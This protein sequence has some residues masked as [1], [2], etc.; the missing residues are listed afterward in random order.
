MLYKTPLLQLTSNNVYLK[1]KILVYSFLDILTISVGCLC[2]LKSFIMLF[3]QS[4][5]LHDL[6]K[7]NVPG[8]LAWEPTDIIYS[9]SVL[10]NCLALQNTVAACR[11]PI[12]TGAVQLQICTQQLFGVV[13]VDLDQICARD[14][15][16]SL[17]VWVTRIQYPGML[18]GSLIYKDGCIHFN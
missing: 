15:S 2:I 8:I 14:H 4:L 17:S 18:V 6:S 13:L 7:L 1:N 16:S 3:Y 11:P 9:M 12:G 5:R 10:L